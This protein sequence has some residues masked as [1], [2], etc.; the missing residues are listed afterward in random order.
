MEK[1]FVD[2]LGDLLR[3]GYWNDPNY[4]KGQ[5]LAL[6]GDGLDMIEAVSKP[7]ATYRIDFIDLSGLSEYQD[8]RV[9]INMPVHVMDAEIDLNDIC[10]VTKIVRHVD[11]AHENQV[12][13][14]NQVISIAGQTFDSILA[15]MAELSNQIDGRKAIFDRASVVGPDGKISTEV[16]EGIIEVNK[17]RLVSAISNWYTDDNGNIVF[18]SPDG[19]NAMMLTGAGFMI[20]DGKDDHGEWRWRTFGTGKGFTADEVIAG[21]LRTGLV[22]ILGTDRFYWDASNIYIIDPLDTK[23]QI[24]I[25]LYDGKNYG[26][27]YT[28][29]GGLNWQNALDFDGLHFSFSDLP[30]AYKIDIIASRGVMLSSGITSTQ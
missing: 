14:S 26:I 1:T 21:E 18:E 29:D 8:E 23:R 30:A 12:E 5:E 11:L 17:N 19:E 25:G 16:L 24:R 13:I 15:R 4:V 20:A 22:R 27:G 9:E 28:Q 3:D 6:Y 10:F 2:T 7:L